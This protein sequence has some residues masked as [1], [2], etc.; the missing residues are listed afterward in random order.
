MDG[1]SGHNV[2]YTQTYDAIGL[3]RT[4]IR[5]SNGPTYVVVPQIRAYPLGQVDLP[6]TFGG[7]TNFHMETLTFEIVD[8]P[9]AYHAILGRPCHAKF[10]AFPNY[11][12]LRV[13]LPDPLG[14]IVVNSELHQC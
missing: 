12:Y 6:M 2:L 3:S 14:T 13:N 4:M 10:M 1:G 9:S 7:R 5:P 11:A 8:L